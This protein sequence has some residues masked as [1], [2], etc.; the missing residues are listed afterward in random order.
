MNESNRDELFA[1]LSKLWEAFPD[2]RFGQ[3][4]VNVSYFAREPSVAATW[5]VEDAEFLD[6]A[7]RLLSERTVDLAENH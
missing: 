1:V 7:K 4:V 6:A 2:M 3:L 5:D